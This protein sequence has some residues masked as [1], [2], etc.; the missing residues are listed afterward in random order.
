M[1]YTLLEEFNSYAIMA[2]HSPLIIQETP[3]RFIQ[4][5]TRI[6]NELIIREPDIECFG[7]NIT[8]ITDDIFDVN[9][10]ESCYKTVLKQLSDKYSIEEIIKLFE[11]K[12][13]LNA[14]I[15]LKTCCRENN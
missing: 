3:S 4:A 1:F 15:F 2:T 7:E 11:D 9:I 8:T 12:L 6:D 10:S 13:S 5:L 14:M